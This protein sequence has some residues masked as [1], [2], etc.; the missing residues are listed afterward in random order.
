MQSRAGSMIE[1]VANVAIGY[2][3]AV[4]ANIVVLPLFGFYPSLAQYAQIGLIF[5][6]IS[7]VRSYCLRRLFNRWGG[8]GS[9]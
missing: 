3:I 8:R 5:T 4:A 7:L 2:G 9:R 6:G 1:A